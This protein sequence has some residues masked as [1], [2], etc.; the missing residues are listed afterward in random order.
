[1]PVQRE[2]SPEL[3]WAPRLLRHY[4][5]GRGPQP[6]CLWSI[7]GL[8]NSLARPVPALGESLR[9]VLRPPLARSAPVL[10]RQV[11]STAQPPALLLLLA[12]LEPAPLSEY[13]PWRASSPSR[14]FSQPNQMS[15]RQIAPTINLRAGRG[16]RR[17]PYVGFFL[18]DGLRGPKMVLR[19]SKCAHRARPKPGSLRGILSAR[20][21]TVYSEKQR[22]NR[23]PITKKPAEDLILSS[24]KLRQR[25]GLRSRPAPVLLLPSKLFASRKSLRGVGGT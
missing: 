17:S 11:R 10:R 16:I 8:P 9:R 6:K 25:G 19:T 22:P 15:T 13:P 18:P 24:G 2:P 20:A 14:C 4:R 5:F 12:P 7:S 23:F 1:M 21:Q 3:P